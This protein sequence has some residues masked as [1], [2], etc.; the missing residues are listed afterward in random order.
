MHDTDRQTGHAR[1][2]AAPTPPSDHVS[3][4]SAAPRRGWV[5]TARPGCRRGRR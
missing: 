2:R 3:C 4:R 1:V 5:R